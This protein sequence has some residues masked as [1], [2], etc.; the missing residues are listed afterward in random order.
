MSQAKIVRVLA[1]IISLL[2]VSFFV[3]TAAPKINQ[4]ALSTFFAPQSTPENPV[5]LPVVQNNIAAQSTPAPTNDSILPP[6]WRDTDPDVQDVE[7]EGTTEAINAPVP[8]P[9][10]P[11]PNISI[12]TPETTSIKISNFRKLSLPSETHSFFGDVAWSPD[13]RK[14]VGHFAGWMAG[15]NEDHLYLG[16]VN[17]NNFSL[18]QTNGTWPSWSQDGEYIY[19][20][21]PRQDGSLVTINQYI[22]RPY[23]DLFRQTVNEKDRESVLV[24]VMPPQ[25]AVAQVFEVLDKQLLMLGANAQ[26]V[27]MPDVSTLVQAASNGQTVV[28]QSVLEVPL[29]GRS[30]DGLIPPAFSI[31]PNGEKSVVIAFGGKS[32]IFDLKTYNSIGAAEGLESPA[33]VAWSSDTLMLAYTNRQ[34]LFT[35]NITTGETKLLVANT[36]LGFLEND[37]RGGLAWPVWVQDDTEIMF[38]ALNQDW[39]DRSVAASDVGIDYFT[40]VTTKDGE[41]IRALGRFAIESVSPNKRHVIIRQLDHTTGYFT[42]LLAD[43]DN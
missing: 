10:V 17:T 33:N 26:I 20:L 12:D 14:F 40:F 25:V 29:I 37:P 36:K 42:S 3:F 21:A 35:Y 15:E 2:L 34:G 28:P 19:Y 5:F 39:V 9:V 22:S 13:S 11:T 18:W 27:V 4:T 23:Y 32:Q 30:A 6:D 1:F 41:N 24:D 7:T 16:D 38:V 43:I 31:S 8:Y